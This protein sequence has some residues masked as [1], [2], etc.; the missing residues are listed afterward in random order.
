MVSLSCELESRHGTPQSFRAGKLLLTAAGADRHD[1]GTPGSG[2]ECKRAEFT[3]EETVSNSL[4]LIAW[5]GFPLVV[6]AGVAAA[7]RLKVMSTLAFIELWHELKPKF[8]AGGPKI[9]LVLAPGGAISKRIAEGE[10]G[11]VVVNPTSDIARLGNDGKAVAGTSRVV[12]KSGV[13]VAVRRGSPKPD[14]STADALRRALLSANAVAYTDPAAGGGSGIHFAKVL[15]RLGIADQVNAK[16]KL[17]GGV[18]NGEVVARGDADIAIQQIPELM[19]VSGVDIVGP[20]PG[21]LQLVT[22]FSA[23]LL[24]SGKDQK[25][26][27]ALIEL[28]TSHEAAAMLKAKGFEVQH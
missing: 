26:A 3:R 11:D 6:P 4:T 1:S 20:L 12:A 22:S 25:A 27:K 28:L 16:A 8:E 21:D 15:Q 7:A 13:G 2:L 5:A 24:S 10:T 9:D 18:L 23:A 14:I 17:G 19:A